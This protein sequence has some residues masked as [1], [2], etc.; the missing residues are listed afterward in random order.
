MP[1]T[2]IQSMA[3]VALAFTLAAPASA[4]LVL[5]GT[6]TSP[7]APFNNTCSGSDCSFSTGTSITDWT[8]SGSG[9]TGLFQP[10]TTTTYYNSGP[11]GEAN[12]SYVV[13]YSNGS[14]I[15]Q[16]IT[17]SVTGVYTF[18]VYIGG[19]RND[20]VPADGT[21]DAV[22]TGGTSHT[23]DA[24]G[25]TAAQGEFSLFTVTFD[26]SAGNTI[27]IQLQSPG[28]QGDFGNVSLTASATPEPGFYGVVALGLS[29]LAF[30]V[31]RR[32]SAEKLGRS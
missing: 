19:E 24:S 13:A 6:F 29:G 27:D 11:N 17:A 26:A 5:N 32:R 30:A 31:V 14:M 15:S 3:L 23:F 7:A 16:V 22:V 20:A 21:A 28:V 9:G 1:K 10:G 8:I 2:F 12:G 18:D 4:N 25:T